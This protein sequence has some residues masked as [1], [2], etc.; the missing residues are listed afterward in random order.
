[1]GGQVFDEGQG[2]GDDLFFVRRLLGF[3]EDFEVFRG[4]D[5][6]ESLIDFGAHVCSDPSHLPANPRVWQPLVSI[7]RFDSIWRDRPP[8]VQP[9]GGAAELGLGGRRHCRR[10]EGHLVR[11][12]ARAKRPE[13]GEL[14]RQ[15]DFRRHTAGV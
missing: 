13:P 8:L 7:K 5:V 10:S 6:F 1:M 11:V 12:D 3:D 14:Q 2:I 4:I 9:A 15:A